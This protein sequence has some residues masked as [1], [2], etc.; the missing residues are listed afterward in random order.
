[1]DALPRPA[2]HPSPQELQDAVFGQLDELT[3]RSV[4]AHARRCLR[5]RQALRAEEDVRRRLLL[6][7][8][9][10]PAVHIVSSVLGCL[11]DP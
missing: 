4:R 11:D 6:L 5:C 1:M 7:E 8:R 3:V 10:A 2:S 9:G